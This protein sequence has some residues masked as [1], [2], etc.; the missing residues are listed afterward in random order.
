MNAWISWFI[1][2]IYLVFFGGKHR[3]H[4]KNNFNKIMIKIRNGVHVDEN[5]LKIIHTLSKNE[6]LLIIN[7]NNINLERINE[8]FSYHEKQLN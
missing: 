6:L 7:I 2:N 3:I 4:N 1:R 5:E 8:C